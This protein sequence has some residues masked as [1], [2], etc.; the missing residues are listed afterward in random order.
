MPHTVKYVSGSDAASVIEKLGGMG[1]HCVAWTLTYWGGG[2]QGGS[3]R[4]HASREDAAA[5]F[6]A[7]LSVAAAVGQR[8]NFVAERE[9]HCGQG[10]RVATDDGSRHFKPRQIAGPRRRS[11]LALTLQNVGSVHSTG[12]A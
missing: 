9:V 4:A 12:R 5:A 10:V 11:V 6:A 2:G 7:N 8:A 3:V 1:R